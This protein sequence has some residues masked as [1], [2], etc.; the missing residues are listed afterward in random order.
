MSEPPRPPP[1]TRGELLARARDR[2]AG[3]GIATAAREAAWIVM[4]VLGLDRAGL[5][6]WPGEAVDAL[7]VRRVEEMARRRAGRE[8]LQYVLGHAEFRGRRFRVDPSVLVPR[9]ETEGLVDRALALLPPR[10]R[11]RVL[12]VGTG[13]GCIAVS[14]ALER[15]DAAVVACDVSGP[16]LETAR[17]NAEALG[18]RV[19]LLPADALGLDF[20]RVVGGPFD[21]VVSNPPYVAEDERSDLEPEVIRH[22]PHIALFAGD[23]PLRYYRVLAG[24]V[25]G[26]LGTPGAALVTEIHAGRGAAVEAV[27][28]DAGLERVA[29]ERDAAGLDRYCTGFRSSS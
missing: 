3:A 24:H 9:P 28:R 15:P 13:S 18:A 16:A 17:F 20:N 8:P 7:D 12:D 14:L 22:E 6:G 27:F 19:Q 10:G 23:D 26:R 5:V 29:V 1:R 21:L 4:E 11:P 2:L 25:A